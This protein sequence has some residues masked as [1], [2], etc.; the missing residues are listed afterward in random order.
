MFFARSSMNLFCKL[1]AGPTRRSVLISLLLLT[2]QACTSLSQDKD[3][4]TKTEA[5][6]P[7][8]EAPSLAVAPPPS[9][10]GLTTELLYD[11]LLSG[12]AYQQGEI[13]VASEALIRAALSSQDPVLITRAVRMAVHNQSYEQAVKLGQGWIELAPQDPQAYIITALAAVMS[14]QGD[15]ATKILKD[16]M[17]QDEALVTFRFSQLGEVFLQHAAGHTV[18]SVL[19][20]LASEYADISEAWLVLAGMAQKNKDFQ[21]MDRALDEILQLEPENEKAAGYKLVALSGD[22]PA[23]EAFAVTFLMANPGV[24][25]FQMQFAQLLLRQNKEAFALDQ[26]LSLLKRDPKNSDALNLVALLYQSQGNY[27]K[28]VDYF[29][30]RLEVLPD[31]DRSRLY[32]ANAYQKL[33][34]FDEAKVILGEVSSSE[35]LF[36]AGRQMSLLVEEADGIEEAL[37][38]LQTLRGEDQAQ[39]IQLIVDHE[40][41]LQR[42]GQVGE[43]IALINSA[44]EQYPDSE[45]LRYHRALLAVERENLELHEADMRVLLRS[46]PENPHYNNTLGYT[47]LVMSDRF[48]E[49]AELI[50]KAHQLKPEDPYIMDSK[51]WLEYKL[52]NLDSALEYLI[53]AFSLDQDAEIAAHLGEV[54]WISGNRDKAREL[55]LE[56]DKIDP[57]NASLKKIKLRFL[58]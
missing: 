1:N 42:A 24:Q 17:A 19:L 35:E 53:R 56:G 26:L 8:A 43:A 4:V 57:D 13:E 18:Q 25:V 41:M 58:P 5:E 14:D 49:A 22:E 16:M 34:R 23:Q 55:W 44:M 28:A 27:L 36:N 10:E 21:G 54:Y 38:Y 31:D 52:D 33:Q 20:Q 12:I 47:L 46:K 50:N 30:R 11:I 7:V 45:T 6:P 40:L 2:L 39:R 32:L 15:T 9:G 29:L 51:G 3:A 48:Q 37:V